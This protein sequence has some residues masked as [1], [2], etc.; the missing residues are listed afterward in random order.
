VYRVGVVGTNLYGQI[1]ARAFAE[2][3]HVHV[4]G[5]AKSEGDYDVDCAAGLGLDLYPNL[6]QMLAERELDVVC[7]CSA[8]ANHADDAL[9]A[10]SR[11]IHVLCERP[12]A[13][14]VADARTMAAAADR[15]RTVLM[16][17]H[18]LRFWPEYV[19]A[20]QIL[21][22]GE[23]GSVRSVTASRVSGTLN[24]EWQNRLLNPRL[25]LGSLEALF[26]DVDYVAWLVGQL[27]LV[28]AQGVRSPGGSWG[29]VQCLFRGIG[30]EIIQAET[31]YLVPLTFPLSMYLR[32]EAE[33]G[34]IVY[35][36][37]GALSSR[38]TS[39][40]RLVVTRDDGEPEVVDVPSADAYAAEV[41][42]FLQCVEKK[43]PPEQGSALQAIRALESLLA[44]A[45][46]A[47]E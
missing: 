5:I 29:Q 31:S 15:E 12:I 43:Q 28:Q 27:S 26:H 8:T 17:G 13:M 39:T 23:L 35:D 30:G 46:S 44:V 22:S 11:G 38:G 9:A 32:V 14:S 19:V 2:Q 41:S 42:Y 18:V 4:V 6:G 7:V 33:Q 47:E 40:R 10:L 16:V 24:P 36:F 20:K 3:P 25:G 1:Y 45:E 37:R 34:T 21:D